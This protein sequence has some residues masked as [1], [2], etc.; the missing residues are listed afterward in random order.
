MSVVSLG[1]HARLFQK[2]KAV[3]AFIAV[4]VARRHG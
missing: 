2:K 3:A 1:F 4:N